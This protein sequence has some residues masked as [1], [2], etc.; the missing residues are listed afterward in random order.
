[1]TN[2]WLRRL[3]LPLL[4]VPLAFGAAIGAA[5]QPE[6]TSLLGIL[7]ILACIW[8]S[9]SNTL[10]AI[11]DEREVYEHERQLFLRNHSYVLSKA[12]I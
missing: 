3:I 1:M 5:V 9:A 10:M 8:M 11:V 12:V 4:I 2:S 7:S 6:E